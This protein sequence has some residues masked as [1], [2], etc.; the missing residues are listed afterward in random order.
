MFEER[1]SIEV[2]DVDILTISLVLILVKQAK[3]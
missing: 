3:M 2:H 1:I